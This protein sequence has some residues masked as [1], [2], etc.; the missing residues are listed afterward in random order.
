[1]WSGLPLS[2]LSLLSMYLGLVCKPTVGEPVAS[3]DRRNGSWERDI[4]GGNPGLA[5]HLYV[6][7][8]GHML[9]ACGPLPEGGG[10]PQSA[11]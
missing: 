1:M 7:R 4:H 8:G 11:G 2:S 6:G 5:I 10:A 9:D 3:G